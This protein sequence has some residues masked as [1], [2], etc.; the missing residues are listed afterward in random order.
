[1]TTNIKN[2]LMQDASR[3]TDLFMK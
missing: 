3:I 2:Q 1:V